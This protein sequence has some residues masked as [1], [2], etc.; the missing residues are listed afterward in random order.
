[1]LLRTSTRAPVR[2]LRLRTDEQMSK[3]WLQDVLQSSSSLLKLEI[4]SAV[5]V[6]ENLICNAV[7]QLHRLQFLV[8]SPALTQS[9]R[10]LHTLTACC[11]DLLSITLTHCGADITEVGVIAL[12][13]RRSKLQEI[14]LS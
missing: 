6:D 14:S 10:T 11:P 7:A 9:D 5:N 3:T 4:V 1:M 8:V 12:C 13:H 2:A